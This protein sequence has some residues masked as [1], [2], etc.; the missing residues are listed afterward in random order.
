MRPDL[1]VVL[2]P[3]LDHDLRIDSIAKPLHR[4]AL[5]AELA[6]EGLVRAVLP[7]LAWIDERRF[8][9]LVSEP[10]QD[11][12]GQELRAVVGS[13][14]SRSSMHADEGPGTRALNCITREA[15]VRPVGTLARWQ[16]TRLAR[17][18]NR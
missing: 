8:D 11:R 17:L 1:V 15:R 12:A 5:I 7:R 14:M 9:V 2:T 3:V 6:V 18:A 10:A 16:L 4:Q 13:Q